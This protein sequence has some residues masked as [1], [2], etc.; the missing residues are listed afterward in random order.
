MRFLTTR[1]AAVILRWVL[2]KT[3]QPVGMTSMTFV[4]FQA[5]A[6]PAKDVAMTEVASGS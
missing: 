4:I 1:R 5:V 2:S 3:P 6:I